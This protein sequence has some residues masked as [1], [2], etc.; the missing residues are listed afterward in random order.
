MFVCPNTACPKHNGCT[1]NTE[2][3]LHQHLRMSPSCM[4]IFQSTI[5]PTIS[6]KSN[7]TVPIQHNHHNNNKSTTTTTKTVS[8]GRAL[9]YYPMVAITKRRIPKFIKPLLADHRG[10]SFV[11]VTESV[12]RAGTTLSRHGNTARMPFCAPF[13]VSR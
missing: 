2:R 5:L 8:E 13:A 10:N 3:G 9:H 7:T 12:T 6:P 4:T 11:A 1:F